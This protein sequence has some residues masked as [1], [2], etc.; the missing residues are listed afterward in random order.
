MHPIA[1][2]LAATLLIL[3][4]GVGAVRLLQDRFIYAPTREAPELD[5]PALAR[6]SAGT[7]TT[8]DGLRLLTWSMPPQRADAPVVLYLHGNGGNLGDRRRRLGR[9]AALGWGAQMVEWRGYGG[10]AGHP[11]EAGLL[12]DARAGLAALQ[13]QGHAAGRIVVWG[14]SL[15]TAVAVAL[16]AERHGAIGAVVLELPFTSL[17]DLAALHFPWLPAPR[18]LLR[19]RFD[20]LATIPGVTVPVLILSGERDILVPP[21]MGEALEG[22]ATAPVERWV[23]PDAGHEELT[24]EGGFAVVTEFLARRLDLR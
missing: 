23:K 4:L 20:S 8:E 13:A 1:W 22:A 24:T 3:V 2:A 14:E 21:W 17:L 9:F 16:A 15:G 6:V 5:E 12:R 7:I 19:D 18:L 10:N 11:S